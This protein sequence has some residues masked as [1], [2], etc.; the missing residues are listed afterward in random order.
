VNRWRSWRKRNHLTLEEFSK[1]VGIS[2]RA[3]VYIE[4]GA[5]RP[6]RESRI[7]FAELKKRYVEADKIKV[8]RSW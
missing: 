5:S 1:A 6:S 7:K 4:S 2:L 8:R 3:V